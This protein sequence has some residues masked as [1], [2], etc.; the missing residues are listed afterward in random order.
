MLVILSGSLFVFFLR[1]TSLARRQIAELSQ[2]VAEYQ[3]TAAPVMEEFRTKLL[4]Y[5]KTHPDF[6]PIFS[7]YFGTNSLTAGPNRAQPF[8][9]TPAARMP[10][11]Q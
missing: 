7:K 4:A 5:T 2:V 9:E 10:T 3:K 11:G 6:G 8:G 1:E